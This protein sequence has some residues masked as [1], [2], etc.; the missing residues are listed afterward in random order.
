[1]GV[2]GGGMAGMEVASLL[3]ERGHDVTIW[4][5]EKV[6]G[7]AF[8]DAG[9]A[10]RKRDMAA[11]ARHK[12]MRL[13]QSRVNIKTET[14]VTEEVLQGEN[15]DILIEAS[16]A[17]FIPPPI[18]GIDRAIPVVH[19]LRNPGLAEGKVVIIGGS[20]VGLEAADLL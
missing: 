11:A 7:G 12:A 19:I 8:L 16:G 4:E 3:S 15:W 14:K 1:M 5:K 2:V 9:L 10:P 20:R 13:A 18:T 6:L 17:E